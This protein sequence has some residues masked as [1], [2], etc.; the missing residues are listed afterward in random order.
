MGVSEFTGIDG[1]HLLELPAPRAK[2]DEVVIEVVT[3]GV[4]PADWK[5]A[6]ATH[7]RVRRMHALPLVPGWGIAGTIAEIG[8]EVHGFAPGDRVYAR[9]LI[10]RQGGYAERIAVR[11]VD[12]APLPNQID[13][14]TAAVIPV[15]GVTAWQGLFEHGKL[16]ADQRILVTGGSGGVGHLAVQLAA[17]AGAW[18]AASTSSRNRRFLEDLGVDRVI[19]YTREKLVDVLGDDPVHL[20]LDSVGGEVTSEC[21]ATVRRGGRLVSAGGFP[22]A[23]ECERAGIDGIRMSAHGDAAA[24]TRMAEMVLANQL[25]PEVS[26]VFDLEDARDAWHESMKGHVRGKLVLRVKPE[27]RTSR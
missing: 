3:A 18:V 5:I 20:A 9:A 8:E 15:A 12:V 6:S 1:L 4:D 13:A 26:A 22:D 27:S 11:A 24:L 7:A 10:E 16:E 19:D 17:N 2:A 25:R 14:V 21:V 23:E